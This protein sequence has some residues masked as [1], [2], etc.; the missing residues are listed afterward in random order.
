MKF[1]SHGRKIEESAELIPENDQ[2]ELWEQSGRVK[3]LVAFAELRKTM[4]VEEIKAMLGG[5][6]HEE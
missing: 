2:Q 6:V 5:A 3:A 1:D 4:T